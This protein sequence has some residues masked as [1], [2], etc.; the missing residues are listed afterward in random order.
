MPKTM[1]YNAGVSIIALKNVEGTNVCVCE[2]E[3]LA[4]WLIYTWSLVTFA[5]TLPTTQLDI[6]CYKILHA[7]T[8]GVGN[9]AGG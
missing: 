7:A 4:S 8:C 9:I 5:L 6:W 2:Y 1:L 3:N